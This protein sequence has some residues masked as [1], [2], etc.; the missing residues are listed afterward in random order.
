[1]KIT[2]IVAVPIIE[3]T[4]LETIGHVQCIV[5]ADWLRAFSNMVEPSG[6]L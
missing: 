6:N 5:H 3:E 4:G 2:L 1:M